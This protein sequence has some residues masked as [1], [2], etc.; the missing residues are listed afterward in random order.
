MREAEEEKSF[1]DQQSTKSSEEDKKAQLKVDA[2]KKREQLMAKFQN[3][4]Q[5][6]ITKNV[7]EEAVPSLSKGSSFMESSNTDDESQI[8]CSLCKETLSIDNFYKE[9]FG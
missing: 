7:K 1:E 9:P 4:R 3:K 8:E 2:K 5:E 6:Y